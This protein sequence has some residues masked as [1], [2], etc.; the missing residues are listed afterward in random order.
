M[1]SYCDDL[2]YRLSPVYAQDPV[3]DALI[4]ALAF[5][6]G[7]LL[8]IHPFRDFNGRVTRM[9]LFALLRRFDLPPVQLVPD[10]EE[11]TETQAYLD[12]LSEADRMNWHPLITIWRNRLGLE[13]TE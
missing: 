5:A 13:A 11:K 9:L 4:E 6:E 3:P 12:A 7:R 8:S 2:E 1:R 10:E